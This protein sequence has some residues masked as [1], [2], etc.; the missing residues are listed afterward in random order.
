MGHYSTI[1]Q[2]LGTWARFWR[3]VPGVVTDFTNVMTDSQGDC[4]TLFPE[5]A[6]RMDPPRQIEPQYVP[7]F[8]PRIYSIDRVTQAMEIDFR[9]YV[10]KGY[11]TDVQIR[12]SFTWGRWRR[13]DEVFDGLWQYQGRRIRPGAWYEFRV[14]DSAGKWTVVTDPMAYRFA[15]RLNPATNQYNLHAIVPSLA[16]DPQA[17]PPRR[18]EALVVCECTLPGLLHRFEGGRYRRTQGGGPSIAARILRSGIIGKLKEQGYTGVMFPIQASVADMRR[19]NWTYNYL[20]HGLGGIDVE[21]GDWFEMKQLVDAFHQAGI[22]VI[23]DIVLVHHVKNSSPRKL[24]NLRDA[25]GKMLWFDDNPYLHRDYGTWMLNLENERIRGHLIEMLVRFI[26]E[27]NLGAFRFDYVDG[28]VLQYAGG[29]RMLP[30]PPPTATGATASSCG[31]AKSGEENDSDPVR[32]L[33]K[34]AQAKGPRQATPGEKFLD[35][36]KLTLDAHGCDVLRISEAFSTREVPA[37][38]RLANVFYEPWVGVVSASDTLG[39]K[40]QADAT[41]LCRTL[42]G[43]KGASVV[44]DSIG[45]MTYVVSHD[46][47]AVDEHVLQARRESNVGESAGAHLSEL[48][49][50]FAESVREDKRMARGDMLDF[51]VRHTCML[52][53][54]TMFTGNYAH[55]QLCGASD[56]AKLGTY[57]DPQGWQFTWDVER[58]PDLNRWM[59]RTG[60]ARA[61]VVKTLAAHQGRM[62]Q[63]RGLYREYTPLGTDSHPPRI[64]IE[65]VGE[66]GKPAAF[67]FTRTDPLGQ[68][69]QVLV[70]FNF[71]D[72]A[73]ASLWTTVP[74][75]ANSR[76]D[77]L[78]ALRS[79]SGAEP[80]V[81][82]AST[83]RQLHLRLPPRTMAIFLARSDLDQPP[84]P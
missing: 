55:M 49:L 2:K 8:G 53:A 31:G 59:K 38:R 65:L 20:I 50:R 36:L 28:L 69:P 61:D 3:W 84:T 40:A 4:P 63:L 13:M 58:H 78:F 12:A 62:V 54:L 70:A 5:V 16:Y 27:L 46:E 74:N 56:C 44:H 29:H 64:S 67:A 22:L 17:A 15:K 9:L 80:G 83:G 52:E 81:A 25:S 82:P 18:D 10:P 75:S 33:V 41:D 79:A 72:E 23:P 68:V 1:A 7:D 47:A 66:S 76:W 26:R 39:R 6:R 51:V 48:A 37:V 43:V 42:M 19:Y 24:E 11:G 30:A 45:A 32:R 21:L 57:D 35:E 73:V 71:A 77:C 60:L 34:A 14:R